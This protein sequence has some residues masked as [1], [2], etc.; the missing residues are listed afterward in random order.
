[1]PRSMERPVLY[2]FII[3]AEPCQQTAEIIKDYY[4]DEFAINYAMILLEQVWGVDVWRQGERIATL[5]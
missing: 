1:M 3:F 4:K 2:H 5:N